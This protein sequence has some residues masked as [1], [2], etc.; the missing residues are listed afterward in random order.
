M[1]MQ[2]ERLSCLR[3]PLWLLVGGLVDTA[4]RSA[5]GDR[6]NSPEQEEAHGQ[7]CGESALG[8][9]IAPQVLKP[10]NLPMWF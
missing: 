10:G 5:A 6:K 1:S 2:V 9:S 8:R 7:Q 3:T 4:A